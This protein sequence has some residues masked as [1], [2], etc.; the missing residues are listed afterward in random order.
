MQLKLGLE[1]ERF[2]LLLAALVLLGGC[3]DHDEE[4]Y[5]PLYLNETD[6][7]VVLI[8]SH[9]EENEPV[10]EIKIHPNDTAYCSPGGIFPILLQSGLH[11]IDDYPLFDV[12]LIFEVD[13]RKCILFEGVSMKNRDIRQFSSYE[14]I[15]ECDFCVERAMSTPYGMLDRITEDMLEAAEPCE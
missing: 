4:R 7:D 12:R 13:P 1:K 3:S 5:E 11:G 8:W 6:N 10:G 2:F 14:N 9:P 15:G